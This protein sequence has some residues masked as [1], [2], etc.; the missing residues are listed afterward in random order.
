MAARPRWREIAVWAIDSRV[1][2]NKHHSWGNN[3][4]VLVWVIGAV[5]GLLVSYQIIR[6]ALSAALMDH[7]EA[8]Q[9]MSAPGVVGM[10]SAPAAPL[11]WLQR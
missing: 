6:A 11:K 2:L 4:F 3:G 10:E 1:I 5:I 7:H 8:V 9:R